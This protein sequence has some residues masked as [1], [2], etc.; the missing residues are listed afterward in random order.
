MNVIELFSIRD[1]AKLFGLTESRLRYW[2]QS[3]FVRP[4]V[5]RNGRFYYT[6]ADLIA[7]RAAK[8]LFVAGA[9]M[10]AVRKALDHLRHSLPSDVSAASRLRVCSDGETLVVVGDDAVYEPTSGQLVM[11]FAVESISQQIEKTLDTDSIPVPMTVRGRE[12]SAPT[13]IESDT[14]ERLERSSYQLFLDGTTAEDRGELALA[15]LYYRRALEQDPALAAA[16]TNLG[17][18][19]YRRNELA[20]ARASYERAVELDPNQNEARYNLGNLLGEIGEVDRAI[21]E[22]KQVVTRAPDFAD[23]HYNLGLLLARV[24]GVAQARHHLSFYLATDGKSEWAARAREVLTQ[25]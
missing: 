21:A 10:P 24:G 25:A 20:L 3:G 12:E 16:H 7:I 19:Y 13:P 17:N 11:A 22:L 6:F 8:E 23:A 15:E 2:L 5:R 4:S 1:A 9:S 14:T 18:I